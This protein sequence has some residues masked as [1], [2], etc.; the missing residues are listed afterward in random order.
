[1]NRRNLL[2][3]LMAA[4]LALLGTRRATTGYLATIHNTPRCRV[5]DRNGR[6]WERIISVHTGTGEAEQYIKRPDGQ[7]Q[8]TP[9]MKA[10]ARQRVTIPTPVI[11][12]PIGEDSRKYA[13]RKPDG[14]WEP[15]NA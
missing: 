2:T 7:C 14:T 4:P 3:A 10:I 1:M 13:R 11:L 12:V 6:Q 15:R 5:Y 9:D 8:L